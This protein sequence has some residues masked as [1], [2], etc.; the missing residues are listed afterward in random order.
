MKSITMLAVFSSVILLFI[1]AC[2][3]EARFKLNEPIRLGT[4]TLTVS[5]AEPVSFPVPFKGRRVVAIF[6]KWT[7]LEQ[8]GSEILSP[9]ERGVFKSL[10]IKFTLTDSSGRKYRS[11]PIP[12]YI[13]RYATL[14]QS[15]TPTSQSSY[16]AWMQQM[17]YDSART[18][19]EWVLLFEVSADEQK[20]TLHLKNPFPE[21]G[22]PRAIAVDL[23]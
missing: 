22:Q 4:T 20:F 15:I 8:G 3:K 1:P 17:Q 21:K 14:Y 23:K 18:P 11:V 9:T 19:E 13:Y 6:I 5:R 16:E 2:F 7:G 12:E 10:F